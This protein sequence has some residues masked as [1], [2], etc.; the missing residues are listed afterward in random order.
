MMKRILAL[1][2]CICGSAAFAGVGLVEFSC[3]GLV[4]FEGERSVKIAGLCGDTTSLA[5]EAGT[6]RVGAKAF[7]VVSGE[8]LRLGELTSKDGQPTHETKPSGKSGKLRV[9]AAEKEE[10]RLWGED[11]WRKG[12]AEITVPSGVYRLEWR[13]KEAVQG[14]LQA[15]DEDQQV[16]L[17]IPHPPQVLVE[18]KTEGEMLIG[19]NREGPP[20]LGDV[21]VLRNAQSVVVAWQRLQKPVEQVFNSAGSIVPLVA[22]HSP[23]RKMAI[24][25]IMKRVGIGAPVDSGSALSLALKAADAEDGLG[26]FSLAIH[27]N[28]GVGVSKDSGRAKILIQSAI[29]KLQAEADRGDAW[30]QGALGLCFIEGLGL[31]KSEARG[32]LLLKEAAKANLS[33]A[34]GSL[35]GFYIVGVGGI[36]D[37][38]MG[39]ELLRKASDRGN[40]EAQFNLATCFAAGIGV[41]KD[42]RYAVLLTKKAAEAGFLTAQTSLGACLLAGDGVE[43]S[44]EEGLKWTR[45]AAE[46]GEMGAQYNLGMCYAEGTGL[47]RDASRAVTWF[48]EAAEQGHAEAQGAL[49]VSYASGNG[50]EK[51]HAIAFFWLSKSAAKGIAYSQLALGVS[52]AN[53]EGVKQ[54]V[55]TAISW[56]RKAAKQGLT[57]AENLLQ[58]LGASNDS[59]Q[60]RERLEELRRTRDEQ[61]KR[62]GM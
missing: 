11:V 49:G 47:T 8:V 32:V 46:R 26:L 50:I 45:I 19:P 31:V 6:W 18:S 48:R 51:D 38:A 3:D 25:S 15:V 37:A 59:N 60:T 23:T 57:E 17:A 30:A 10:W 28:D 27:Y 14:R 54:D 42:V 9:I 1:I 61:S 36:K 34:E 20:Q 24:E 53:G 41:A 29:P 62:R 39:V 40:A 5:L 16:P 33:W 56:L 52:Y 13:E 4:V 55:S 21:A 12:P 44:V 35:G 43:K 2:T 58:Q 7:E 22:F